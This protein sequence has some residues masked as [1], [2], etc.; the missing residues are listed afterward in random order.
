MDSMLP[1]SLPYSHW[2]QHQAKSQG[3]GPLNKKET[4]S[5]SDLG[6]SE[7]LEFKQEATLHEDSS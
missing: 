6:A 5:T 1:H 3:L 2:T 4:D 7:D